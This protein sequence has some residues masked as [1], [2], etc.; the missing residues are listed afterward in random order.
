MADAVTIEPLT[1]SATEAALPELL[2]VLGDAVAGG[3]SVGFLPPLAAEDGRAYWRAVGAAIDA[4]SRVL[5]V[6]R[7]AGGPIVGTVQLDL[8]T[9]ANG[10]HRAEVSKLL[11][12]RAARRRGV[13]RRL[14]LALE[15]EAQRL[16]RTTIVLD[17]CQGDPSEALYAGLG[18]QLIGAIPAYARSADGALHATAFYYKLLGGAKA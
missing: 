13:G 2:A 1:A 7:V 5:L 6:A 14:M 4:G 9:R 11:V 16:G 15:A 18:Y 12:A 8:A 10:L 3:A 17:T